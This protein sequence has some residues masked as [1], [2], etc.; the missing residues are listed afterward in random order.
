MNL[1]NKD[2]NKWCNSKKINS[3]WKYQKKK[4]KTQN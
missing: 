3:G 1:M 2:L 4:N